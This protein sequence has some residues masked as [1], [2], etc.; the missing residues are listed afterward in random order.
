VDVRS[1]KRADANL[2]G[3]VALSNWEMTHVPRAKTHHYAGCASFGRT[4][5]VF[6][7]V[8]QQ[9]KRNT[10]AP[11]MA[12]QWSD[13]VLQ[14]D[15]HLIAA[16]DTLKAFTSKMDVFKRLMPYH[17]FSSETEHTPNE[18]RYSAAYL[19]RIAEPAERARKRMKVLEEKLNSE[20]DLN[21]LKK[22]SEG[23]FVEMFQ[24]QQEQV[25]RKGPFYLNSC[26]TCKTGT[27]AR[28]AQYK[29]RTA[30]S[31]PYE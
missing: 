19:M 12:S 31:S 13:Q 27:V 7:R 29:R 14:H 24:I 1:T 3:G 28:E 22:A 6:G 5:K 10:E 11:S 9:P 25:G 18:G 23:C 15:L 30:Y 20:G 17:I 8:H 21:R 2:I 16:P 4:A 26:L